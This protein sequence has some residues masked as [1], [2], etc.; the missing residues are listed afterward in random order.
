VNA[1]Y[2]SLLNLHGKVYAQCFEKRCRE[3]I[4]PKLD[5]GDTHYPVRFSSA[6]V[7]QIKIS[8]SSKFSKNRG[9]MPKTSTRVLSTSRKHTTRFFV[10]SC[11]EYCERE[12]RVDDCL[13]LAVKSLYSC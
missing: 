5:L 6:V 9:S 4:A 3:I 2:I 1:W 10:K 7:L 12:Y 11:C 13:L 8:L